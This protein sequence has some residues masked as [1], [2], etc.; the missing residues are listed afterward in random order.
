MSSTPAPLRPLAIPAV[1]LLSSTLS[2]QDI[3]AGL[4]AG[5]P[6]TPVLT[7]DSPLESS[8]TWYVLGPFLEVQLAHG[9]GVGADLLLRRTGLTIPPAGSHA[10]AWL[11]ELPVTLTYRFHLAARP[12]VR[13]G[14]SLN[15]VFDISG[16]TPCARGPFGEQFYC[17][18]GTSVLELRHRGTSGF[19]F[20]A[21]LQL[22]LRHVRLEPE[23]RVT[24]WI[25]RNFGVRGSATRSDLNEVALLIGI[26][27]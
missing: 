19:V 13:T 22:H 20:G 9:F 17:V 18:D 4:R 14:L 1:L 16:A 23:A 24:H 6:L 11:W 5:L 15:R 25:D 12:F 21:G 7:A 3:S 26:G 27:F 2:A 8:T 10:A